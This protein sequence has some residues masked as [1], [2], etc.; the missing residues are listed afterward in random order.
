MHS[1]EVDLIPPPLQLQ[2]RVSVDKANRHCLSSRN[3]ITLGVF[4]YAVLTFMSVSK[5]PK[6]VGAERFP[7]GSTYVGWWSADAD[8][9][10]LSDGFGTQYTA[11]S[12]GGL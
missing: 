8:G 10:Y 9:V 12:D 2:A 5:F 4:K 7:N 6:T 11:A 3:L 1:P